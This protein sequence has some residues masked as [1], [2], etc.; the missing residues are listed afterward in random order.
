[1]SIKTTQTL[2]RKQALY[3][4]V[5]NISTNNYLYNLLQTFLSNKTL[6]D[7]LEEIDE[8]NGNPFTNYIVTD[9]T[10]EEVKKWNY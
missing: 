8:N 6:E 1:M 4:L 2:T 9:D 10:D 3:Q 7:I 5:N